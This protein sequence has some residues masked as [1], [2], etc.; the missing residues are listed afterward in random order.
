MRRAEPTDSPRAVVRPAR[1]RRLGSAARRSH[2]RPRLLA[3]AQR[4]RLQ[5]RQGRR[6]APTCWRRATR[7][8]PTSSSSGRTRTPISPRCLQQELAG[9]TARY[10]ELK[11][12]AGALDFADLLVRA[13]DL[14]RVERRRAPASA[15]EVH[16]DL[17]RRVPGY[18][19]GAGR[20]PAAAARR[21]DRASPPG[22]LF[23]VGDPK[24]AIYRFRGTD[25]GTYW[26]V[27]RELEAR[28]GRVLQLTTSYR[29]VP[30]IQRFVNAAFAQEM[31][32]DDADAAGRLRA[33]LAVPRPADDSQ[34]AIV[35]L[36]VPKP[37]PPRGFLKPSA[38]AIEHRCQTRSARSLPG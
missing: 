28:G 32:A 34:P 24:Q 27:S 1:S 19:S 26:S 4:Q 33:A 7:S 21:D 25:V 18:R 23:I 38:K 6:R 3:D 8:S 17:R 35:A 36:P 20:D 2:A 10:Q 22:K 14:I 5:V 37:Y 13:R 31:I 11:A 29:S 12:A 30:A 15:A 9:A 16:A